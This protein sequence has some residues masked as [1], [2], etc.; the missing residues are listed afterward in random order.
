MSKTSPSFTF[1]PQLDTSKTKRPN[2]LSED[3]PSVTRLLN[4]KS[5]SNLAV[6]QPP[7]ASSPTGGTAT[8]LIRRRTLSAPP[9]SVPSA[10]ATLE[11]PPLE[12]AVPQNQRPE[13]RKTRRPRPSEKTNPQS[14]PVPHLGRALPPIPSQAP[15]LAWVLLERDQAQGEW[16][17][18]LSST[19]LT[20]PVELAAFQAWTQSLHLSGTQLNPLLNATMGKSMGPLSLEH[21]KLHLLIKALGLTQYPQCSWLRAESP[22]IG[23]GKSPQKIVLIGHSA[24][25][26]PQAFLSW[27]IQL[28]QSQNM[29]L[30]TESKLPE[31]EIPLAS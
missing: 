22:A 25:L 11:T 30:E 10:S 28:T 9:T 17:T 18:T 29:P 24:P 13:V 8:R 6:P 15:A 26:E 23:N 5:L 2:D 16:S 12:A 3:V 4:R 19:H 7:E 31:L 20:S 14:N 27:A 1:D 21:P